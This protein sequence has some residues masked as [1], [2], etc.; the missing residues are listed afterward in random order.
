M[1]LVARGRY[2]LA[3][4]P[5]LYW[6]GVVALA[7]SGGLVVA[8]AAA[9]I[10]DARQAWGETRPVVVASADIAPGDALAGRASIRDRPSPAVPESALSS[11]PAGAVA[12]Q[13]I[14]AGEAIVAADVAATAGPRSL[15][16]DGWSAVAVAE[17]VPSGAV[18]GD[19]VVAV[20]GGVVLAAEGMVVGHAGEA[21]LV[22]VPADE[23]PQ[24][25][26]A[27]TTGELSLLLEP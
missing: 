12:R 6:L 21:V 1:S 18:I 17:A 16:P 22:A 23:A 9:G 24:V 19:P 26:H 13:H 14:A 10:D 15:V 25:A 11:L 4:R 20:A 8:R 5:W 27:A 7:A 3:R 2:T